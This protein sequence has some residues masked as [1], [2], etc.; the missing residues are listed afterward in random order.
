[1]RKIVKMSAS[2]IQAKTAGR[3]VKGAT[4]VESFPVVFALTTL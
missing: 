2:G 1:M 3:R 4:S